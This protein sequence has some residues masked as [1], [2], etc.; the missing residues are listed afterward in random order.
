MASIVGVRIEKT[1]YSLRGELTLDSAES[2]TA[3]SI[4]SLVTIS[5]LP[6]VRKILGV[7]TIN[8][9]D[10]VDSKVCIQFD[11]VFE[12]NITPDEQYQS[13]LSELKCFFSEVDESVR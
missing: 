7:I 8:R 12:L 13:W 2:S 6:L 10:W 5:P 11:C 9:V 4:A 3:S 1:K